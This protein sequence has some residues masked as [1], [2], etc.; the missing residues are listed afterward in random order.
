MRLAHSEIPQ[1]INGIPRARFRW[2]VVIHAR[3]LLDLQK[4]ELR[5]ERYFGKHEIGVIGEEVGAV[6]PGVVSWESKGSGGSGVDY[7][8]FSA[9][10]CI[11][12]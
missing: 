10:S 11:M 4:P 8:R 5:V 1:Q 2:R 12:C 9:S 7:S 6:L 3:Y